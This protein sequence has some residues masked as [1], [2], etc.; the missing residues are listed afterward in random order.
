[1]GSTFV[2]VA[3]YKGR[4]FLRDGYHR[5]VSLLRAGIT[6]IPCILIE[7]HS[8][9][10]IG[11]EPKVMFGYETLFGDRPPMLS[12]FF[13]ESVSVD[14]LQPAIRKVVRVAGEQF[15]ISG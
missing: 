8:F 1:M 9:E 3:H 12:D 14:V 2:Q 6:T 15:L 11:A 5:A 10:E 4:F 7:A 13:N